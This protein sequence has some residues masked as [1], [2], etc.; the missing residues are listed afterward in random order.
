MTCRADG[1][2]MTS[3]TS[4]SY[5]PALES[6]DLEWR[7]LNHRPAAV[8]H[9]VGWQVVSTPRCLD[10]VVDAISRVAGTDDVLRRLVA[11][12]RH[13][14]LAARVVLQRMLPGFVR[15]AARW[16]RRQG[17]W[18]TAFDEVLAAG[19]LV[20][21]TIG[22]DTKP[23]LAARILR[24][25]EYQAFGR[26]ARRRVTLVPT[27]VIDGAA[28][29]V[30]TAHAELAEVVSAAHHVL[31]DIDRHVLRLLL[32]E[33]SPPQMAAELGVSIRTVT[34]HRHAMVGRLQAAVLS[35]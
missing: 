29:E 1:A 7:T 12:A 26:A 32:G 28:V 11:L 15:V 27:E 21:Q 16:A 17:G 5:S 34:N 6:L 14:P 31:T 35:R 3:S 20:L 10:D 2:T 25:V 19:W 24:A 18:A 13:D 23:Q 8:R 9:A 22:D 30:R 33:C 4:S